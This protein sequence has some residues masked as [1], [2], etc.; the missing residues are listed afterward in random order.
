LNILLFSNIPMVG[1]LTDLDTFGLGV[2]GMLF[3]FCMIHQMVVN[4]DSKSDLY[5]LRHIGITIVETAA[6][7][8]IIPISTFL[9]FYMFGTAISNSILDFIL[10]LVVV[11]M[12]V[13]FIRQIPFTTKE[14]RKDFKRLRN[15]IEQAPLDQIRALEYVKL[16][17]NLCAYFVHPQHDRHKQAEARSIKTQSTSKEDRSSRQDLHS[18]QRFSFWSVHSQ[19]FLQ[20]EDTPEES[21]E[22]GHVSLFEMMLYNWIEYRLI[23]YTSKHHLKVILSKSAT[24]SSIADPDLATALEIEENDRISPL[25]VDAHRTKV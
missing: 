13:V 11:C 1:Y 2:Y 15:K 6:R 5:P 7:I 17:S 20:G 24:E 10:A 3:I 22:V 8:F 19:K 21:H 14:L 23:E 4:M 12:T 9:F 18:S 25:A 16:S